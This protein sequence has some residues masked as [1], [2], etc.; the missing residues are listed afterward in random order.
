VVPGGHVKL[1]LFG[2]AD[3]LNVDLDW[4]KKQVHILVWLRQLIAIPNP[5]SRF[6]MSLKRSYKQKGC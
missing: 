6:H 3:G 5:L 4:L 1:E 2:V